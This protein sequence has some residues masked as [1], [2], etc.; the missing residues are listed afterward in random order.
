MRDIDI[1]R[2]HELGTLAARERL[3]VIEKE[4]DERFGVRLEWDADTATVRGRGVN[5][6]VVIDDVDLAVR[7]RI[8]LLFAPLTPL[9]RKEIEQALERAFAA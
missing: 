5:G 4:L 6:T 9:I 7:L 1:G 3:R 8:G 2:R